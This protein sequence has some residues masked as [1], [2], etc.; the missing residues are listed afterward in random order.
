MAAVIHRECHWH[1]VW[2]AASVDGVLQPC[3]AA[4]EDSSWTRTRWTNVCRCWD[5]A[6]A[7]RRYFL[8]VC[9]IVSTVLD[10]HQSKCEWRNICDSVSSVCAG[11]SLILHAC[12]GLL[13]ESVDNIRAGS[14]MFELKKS[15]W[16]IS[17]CIFL[18]F[19]SKVLHM[20]PQDTWLCILLSGLPCL[21]PSW[22]SCFLIS[23]CL[24]VCAAHK[25]VSVIL[26]SV[27]G[28]DHQHNYRLSLCHCQFCNRNTQLNSKVSHESNN[29]SLQERLCHW[30]P[31]PQRKEKKL[32][33]QKTK[34]FCYFYFKIII[35][36]LISLTF[37]KSC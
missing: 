25:F 5:K 2:F 23:S 20:Q 3:E 22:I 19:Y 1:S 18:K 9:V 15:W 29:L 30:D 6:R 36:H 13:A 10:L 31:S 37:Q 32:H 4:F 8:F 16:F 27:E 26:S 34:I 28:K 7:R 35:P 33:L 14:D 17:G 24:K 11:W 21:G 12:L